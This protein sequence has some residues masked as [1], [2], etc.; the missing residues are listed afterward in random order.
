MVYW[1]ILFPLAMAA[2]SYAVPSSRWR[3]WLLPLGGLGYLGLALTALGG[4]ALSA[5]QAP[6]LTVTGLGGWLL[7]DALGSIVLGLLAVLFFVCSL[8][9]PSYLALR[10]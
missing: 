1:L 4:G 10:A 9:A 7:L 6:A 3:P 5:D 8:Y 2:G